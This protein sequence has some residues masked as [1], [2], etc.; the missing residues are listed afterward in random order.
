MGEIED[1]EAAQLDGYVEK[2]NPVLLMIW[3]KGCD[4][5]RRFKPVFNQLPQ[6][7]PEATFLSMSMFS[8]ME[9]LR[10]A[11]KYE[12]ETTPIIPVFCKGMHLGTFVGYY[13]LEDFRS[14]M[15]EVFRE[16]QC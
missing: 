11:E 2:G 9:N 1:I 16:N 10:L 8:S 5:C 15:D 4:Q 3:R 13:S 12:K 14:K 7:Y 6:S